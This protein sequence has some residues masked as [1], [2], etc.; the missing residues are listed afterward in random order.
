MSSN[1]DELL[2]QIPIDQLAG[3]L[4]VSE[5]ETKQAVSQALPA[6]VGGMAENAKDPLGAASLEKALGQHD[7]TLLEGGIDLDQVDTVDGEKIVKNVFGDNEEAVVNQLGGLGGGAG[8]MAV[9][10]ADAGAAADV[11]PRQVAAAGVAEVVA[12]GSATSSAGCS[13]AAVAAE[14]PVA[15]GMG[16]IG[17]VLGGLLGGGKK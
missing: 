5:D 14:M 10:A 6:L 17:D 3:K 15:A 7:G 9:A 8:T 2:N 12:A 16:D 11:L 13:A 1:I 4:G